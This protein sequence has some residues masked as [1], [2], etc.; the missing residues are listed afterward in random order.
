MI[1]WM[2]IVNLTPDSFFESSRAWGAVPEAS[3]V[4][5][6]GGVSELGVSS[7]VSVPLA[8]E[9]IRH[10]AADGATIIDLGAVSTRPGA[11]EVSPEE[12]WER[13]EP[14]LAALSAL[15]SAEASDPHPSQSG[16]SDCCPDL[17]LQDDA[18]CGTDLRRLLAP[19][20]L[21]I[22]IDTFRSGIV[23]RAYSLIG[24][25]IVNDISAGEDDP[26]MLPTVAELGLQY[27]AMHKRGA[28]GTMDSLCDY[29]D[30]V[31]PEL[32]RY[33]A[34]FERRAAE[35]G[36]DRWILDPGLGFAKTVEQNWEILRRLPELQRFGRPILI[37]AADKR[38][39]HEVPPDLAERYSGERA[40]SGFAPAAPDHDGH[41]SAPSPVSPTAFG[42]AVAHRLALIGG[43][44]ILRVHDI[45]K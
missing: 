45:P 28:P 29:P 25:F 22:S 4:P 36:V 23:Q 26:Q 33:F 19:E 10:L 27:V 17:R 21:Q 20:R 3:G 34:D 30:G 42:T 11:A 24:D 41:L 44:A 35:A 6:A 12:E 39:T 1:R 2:G 13:L 9:K 31:M 5:G 37:G 15:R 7:G 32:L 43:A 18:D 8:L 16:D 14:V 38:F 40:A